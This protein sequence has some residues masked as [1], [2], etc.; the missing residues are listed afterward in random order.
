MTEKIKAQVMDDVAAFTSMVGHLVRTATSSDDLLDIDY[1]AHYMAPHLN[2]DSR[3]VR[4]FAEQ[5]IKECE[6]RKA[7]I[8]DT[9]SKM[10]EVMS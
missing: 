1:V 2:D 5:V 9:K 7:V 6:Y 10:L 3:L 8:R 4:A